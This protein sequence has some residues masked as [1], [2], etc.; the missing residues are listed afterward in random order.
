MTNEEF[1]NSIKLEG[2]EWR[3]VVGYE[4]FYMVSSYGRFVSLSRKVPT[5]YGY[6]IT[7][8]K[9]IK[10]S[11]HKSTGYLRVTLSK[12]GIHVSIHA[13]RLVA[14]SFIPN[15]YAKPM[16][17]HLDRNKHNNRIN[18][19]R[20]CTLSENMNNPLTV[21]H[22][23][24]MNLGREYPTLRRPV[25]ALK[26]G[27]IAKQYDSIKSAIA[28]GFTNCGIINCCAGRDQS[29]YGYKWMY[30]SDYENLVNK[31]KNSLPN[32]R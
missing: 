11:E 29:H 31:S 26:D 27:V 28:D 15:P 2:E 25:V 17:D 1:I 4:G 8:P 19:L 16:I 21:E 10:P 20:W 32:S 13:H 14:S 9:L 12:N 24:N 18:N 6:R 22:C 7:K 3:D 30:L 23:R 5:S